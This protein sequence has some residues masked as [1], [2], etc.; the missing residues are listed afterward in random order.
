VRSTAHLVAVFDHRVADGA[1][2]GSFLTDLAVL[3][4]EPARAL[5]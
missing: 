5:R 2:V 1:D 3:V 4:E